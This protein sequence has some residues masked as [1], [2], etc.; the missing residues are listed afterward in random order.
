LLKLLGGEIRVES[1]FGKGSN[2]TFTVP[3]DIRLASAA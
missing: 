1:D 3:S 2:F